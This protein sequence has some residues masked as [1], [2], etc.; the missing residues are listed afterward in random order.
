MAELKFTTVPEKY[1]V[2]IEQWARITVEKWEFQIANKNLIYSGD[3]LRSF[4]FQINRDAGGDIL[5]ITFAF[6]YYIRMLDMG[7]GKGVHKDEVKDSIRK[8]HNFFNKVF[9]SEFRRLSELMTEKYKDQALHI[10]SDN[11]TF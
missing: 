5:L 10:I 6:K 2:D 7:V 3:L 9:Y 11:V 8:P 4:Q 1:T